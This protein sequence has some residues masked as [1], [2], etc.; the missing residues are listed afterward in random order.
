MRSIAAVIL[1]LSKFISLVLALPLIG[2]DLPVKF[3][4]ITSE[5]GLSQNSVYSILQGSDGFM[6][7][8]TR[9]GLNRYDG[10]DFK[11]FRHDLSDTTS[12]PG[13]VITAIS[14][15]QEGNLWVGIRGGGLAV[16]N[17]KTETFV[18]YRHIDNAPH[19][20]A[21]NYVTALFTDSRGTM[22]IGT[23]NGL[24]TYNDTTDKFRTFKHD[25]DNA[26]SIANSRISSISEMPEG[27]LWVGAEDG[28]LT[29]LSL[30]TLQAEIVIPGQVRSSVQVTCIV[31]DISR[32]LLWVGRFGHT[33]IRV[34]PI[35]HEMKALPGTRSK[36]R[37]VIAGV[38]T[39]SL[40]ATGKLWIG[41]AASVTC[42]DP[43]A[44]SFQVFNAN[45]NDSEALQDDMVYASYIDPQG[46]VW[47]GTESGGVSKFDPGLIRFKHVASEGNSSNSILANEIF[48]IAEDQRGHIWFGTLGGGTSVLSPKT[49]VFSHF[50]SNDLKEGWSRNYI[51]KVLP[52]Q[53]QTVWLGAFASGLFN[54]DYSTGD[55][56]HYKNDDYNLQSFGDKTTRAL[57]ETRDGTIW[58]GTE[59]QG[60]DRFNSQDSTFT[61]FKHNPKDPNSISS[62]LTYALL[63]D[64]QGFIWI[65]TETQGLDQFDPSTEIFTHFNAT[66]PGETALGANNVLSIYEDEENT[67]WVGTRGGG[68]NQLDSSR[69]QVTQLKLSPELTSLAVYGILQDAQDFLWLSTNQG[70]LKAHP[71]TGLV[72]SYTRSDG[73]QPDFYYS[74]CLEASDG[75]MYFGGTTGYTVFHPDSIQN[76]THIPPVVITGLSVNYEDVPIGEL[77]GNRTLLSESITYTDE[78]Q[79]DYQDKVIRFKFAALGYSASYKNQYAYRLEGYD[80]DWIYSGTENIA[81]YMNL[82]AGEYVF[83]VRGTNNDGVWNKEGTSISVIISPPFWETWWF[84]LVLVSSLLGFILLYIHLRTAKLRDQRIKL[85]VVVRERTSELKME[86]EE[87]QQIESEKTQQQM[88]HL[89]RELLT[90]TLHL[91]DKQQIMDNLQEQLEVVCN[92]NGENS[93]PRLKKLLRFLKDRRSVKQ[94]WEDF[95]LWFTE[96]HTGFY[97]DLRQAYP[98]LSE[99]ELKVCALLRLKMISKDIA[100]VMNVQPASVDIY[101]HRIRKKL[102]LAS[103]ENL[104]TFLSQY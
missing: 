21:N 3:E 41:S 93:K 27:T 81:Q 66:S 35:T 11:V 5:D 85:E 48:S 20:L 65:G 54:L 53:D 2:S 99:S 78:I 100:N 90:Q 72:R 102:D 1:C 58:I 98:T 95:E 10:K 16:F 39:M 36:S 9:F 68:L 88:D 47:I 76:N 34:D 92:G 25:P 28:S 38:M 82:P 87:R 8:G 67:L 49:G 26:E 19:S 73:V 37:G 32:N 70:I 44:E 42:Y 50:V 55:F 52:A 83:Q 96:V 75:T 18:S 24:C 14:E 80:E 15:D 97:S 23:E 60:L 57:L 94:G 33:V 51:A 63:E 86:I 56:A 69:K 101:R 104:S 4:H 62:N 103:D 43:D 7:F 6:W 12:I 17:K 64:S 40:D 79:L 13:H 29:K 91:N 31:P 71:D 74:S 30:N 89:K 77:P 22:W 84:K 45:P 46:I 61:H 59:T